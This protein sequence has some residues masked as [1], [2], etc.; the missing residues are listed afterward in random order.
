MTQKQ[1]EALVEAALKGL[2]PFFLEKM[3]NVAV[4][5]KARPTREQAKKFGEDL[6]GLYEGVPLDQRGTDYSG[7][8]PDK[9]TIFRKF[10]EE[11]FATPEEM[12]EEVRLTVMHELAHHFGMDDDELRQKGLY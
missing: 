9:I 4:V 3:R 6:Y 12:A 10:I 7:A 8:M 1:F 5:V 2:P 11:D